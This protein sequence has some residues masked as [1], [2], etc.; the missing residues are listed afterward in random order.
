M[1]FMLLSSLR[2]FLKALKIELSFFAVYIFCQPLNQD[3]PIKESS[4]K[5]TFKKIFISLMGWKN[6]KS[7]HQKLNYF[8]LEFCSIFFSK[9]T[10]SHE[11]QKGDIYHVSPFIPG[12]KGTWWHTQ[13][14]LFQKNIKNKFCYLKCDKNSPNNKVF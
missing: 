9:Y 5:L 1:S 7:F 6:Q 2:H 8:L 13:P 14:S 3:F 10:F 12:W 11:A 4:D